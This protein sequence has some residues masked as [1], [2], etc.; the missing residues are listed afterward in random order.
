MERV[1]DYNKN[2]LMGLKKTSDN[3]VK[4]ITQ[5]LDLT[6]F[7]VYGICILSFSFSSG[8][9][10]LCVVGGKMSEGINFSDD[11]GRCVI[12]VGMPYPNITS[13]ELQVRNTA[14][15]F[16]SIYFLPG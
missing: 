2:C 14:T 11:L 1:L 3:T 16:C 15:S 8:A 12:M 7:T 6:G 5:V 13:P 10:L 4:Q 9:I